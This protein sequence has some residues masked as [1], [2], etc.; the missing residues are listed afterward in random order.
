[1]GDPK[2]RDN[3]LPF[4]GTSGQACGAGGYGA[5]CGSGQCLLA[6]VDQLPD[7]SD[8][9]DVYYD[10]GAYSGGGAIPCPSE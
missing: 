8:G 6:A 10:F 9:A 5:S 4:G 3:C 2:N 7:P 1:M